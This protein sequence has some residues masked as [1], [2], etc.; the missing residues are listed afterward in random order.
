MTDKGE[1]IDSVRIV[2]IGMGCV[3]DSDHA[4]MHYVATLLL[5]VDDRTVSRAF[6]RVAADAIGLDW[7]ALQCFRAYHE[8]LHHGQSE[9]EGEV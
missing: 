1:T 3:R 2:E 9:K 8:V 7:R 6:R 5:S 4:M